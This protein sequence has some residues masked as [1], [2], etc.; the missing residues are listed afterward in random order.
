[1]NISNV[2]YGTVKKNDSVNTEKNKSIFNWMH[3]KSTFNLKDWR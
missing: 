3:M 1:M 2:T